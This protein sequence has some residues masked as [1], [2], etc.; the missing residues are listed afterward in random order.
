M[1]ETGRRMPPTRA[2][3]ADPVTPN[4]TLVEREDLTDSIV[5]LRL[6]PDDGVPAFSP[7]QYLALGLP[8]GGR[9]VQRPYSTA[10]AAGETDAL[11]FLVRL[12]PGGALTPRLWRTAVGDRTHLGRPKGRFVPD[13]D[14][15]RRPVFIA[16][17]T[18]I[19]PLMAML[20]TRLRERADGPRGREPI[21]VH[22]VARAAD[23]A[24]SRPAAGSRG[25]AQGRVRPG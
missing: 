11:E 23:L 18:G 10:S 3:A 20:E 15:V 4:A 8:A 1:V 7:G 9:L 13:R 16:T 2:T 6:R 14:D 21:V 19:A 25:A 22:G 5:R 17:G 24:Y 12:V